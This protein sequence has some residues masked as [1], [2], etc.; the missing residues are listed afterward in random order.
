MT[1]EIKQKKILV[2]FERMR[3]LY[4][5][6][7]YYNLNLG[8]T[9]LRLATDKLD[10]SFYVVPWQIGIFGR[11]N[12]YETKKSYLPLQKSVFNFLK[13]KRPEPK[14]YDIIHISDQH[15]TFQSRDTNAKI[16]LT[17][18]DLNYL[19]ESKDA[20][21]LKKESE[22]HQRIVD[23]ADHIVCISNFSR[24]T[25][26]ANL[27][28]KNKPVDVI[29]QGCKLEEIA[30][31]TQPKYLP[32]RPFIFTISNLYPKKNVHVLP[33]LLI[34]NEY[35]LVISGIIEHPQQKAYVKVILANAKLHG[36]SDRVIIT[37][38]VSDNDKQ[39]YYKNCMAFMFPSI[40]EGF[41]IPPLEAMYFGKP[42]FASTH[43]S[44]PEICGDAAYYFKSFEPAEM[45]KVFKEGMHHY[46]TVKPLQI[47]KD[48]YEFFNWEKT[49]QAYIELYEKL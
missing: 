43:T 35:E 49:A 13:K 16:I 31:I 40:A 29:Y 47:L 34:G 19:V 6:F 14:G 37:G 27:D 18:H 28:T 17:I 48:R 32:K 36:V 4:T 15:S 23:M 3:D 22:K 46:E 8:R 5:G 24:N 1:K 12:H 10:F 38:P 41:G 30:T 33:C 21:S 9:L 44:V 42:V 20:E 11:N 25:V 45:I 26:L 39:W 7:Y 2:E